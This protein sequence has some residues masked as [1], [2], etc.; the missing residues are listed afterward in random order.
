MTSLFTYEPDTP[1]QPVTLCVCVIVLVPKELQ[2][3]T[4]QQL[5]QV[6]ESSK[7]WAQKQKAFVKVA[8][9]LIQTLDTFY[10]SLAA[11]L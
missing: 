5:K 1:V 10:V 6:S 4:E 9:L 2:V 11:A 8:L 7:N 3:S